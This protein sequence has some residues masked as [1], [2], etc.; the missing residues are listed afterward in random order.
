MVEYLQQVQQVNLPNQQKLQQAP[1]QLL[2]EKA[3]QILQEDQG[4]G[5]EQGQ[6]QG[7]G[8]PD[9]KNEGL[10]LPLPPNLHPSFHPGPQLPPPPALDQLGIGV[11]GGGIG[12]LGIG[13][14]PPP[15]G[16]PQVMQADPD[17]MQELLY[18][19]FMDKYRKW[20][21]AKYDKPF[22]F[23]IF[24]RTYFD[25][26]RLWNE[27]M[28]RGGSSQVCLSK[29]WAEIGRLFNPPKYMTNLSSIIR[30]IYERYLLPYEQEVSPHTAMPL[31]NGSEKNRRRRRTPVPRPTGPLSIN[32]ADEFISLEPPSKKQGIEGD[33]AGGGGSNPNTV[34]EGVDEYAMSIAQNQQQQRGNEDI[35]S[36]GGSGAGAN[37]RV[38]LGGIGGQEGDMQGSINKENETVGAQEDEDAQLR[39]ALRAAMAHIHQL[40]AHHTQEMQ[41]LQSFYQIR[42]EQMHGRVQALEQ[43]LAEARFR[44]QEMLRQNEEAKRH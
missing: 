41:L 2:V 15:P 37:D 3:T 6:G 14:M 9:F 18:T 1:R 39:D 30:S 11:G 16:G 38:V 23:P 40:K 34:E 4:Q 43:Q 32:M 29:S 8:I 28:A 19:H 5:Q 22:Q 31:S 44:Y 21:Q 20:Y 13:G 26:E 33:P 24:N 25:V 36:P 12:G 7:Q 10:S 42:F 35:S 27:V 17:N